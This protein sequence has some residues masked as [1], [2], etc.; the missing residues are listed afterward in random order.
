MILRELSIWDLP[1]L[2]EVRND[3]TTRVNLENNSIFTLEECAEWFLDK[4]PN[5]YIIEVDGNSVGYIRTNGDEVGADIHPKY[6]KM[7]YAKQA[8][9]IYLKDKKSASLWVFNDNFAKNLY[10][11]L[12]FIETGNKKIIR[13]REYIQMAYKK[14]KIGIN[15]VGVSFDDGSIYRYRSYKDALDGFNKNIVQSL[16]YMGHDFQFYLYTYDSVQKEN[17]IKDYSPIRK[18]KFITKETDVLYNSFNLNSIQK[19]NYVNSLL[20]MLNEELDLVISTRYDI[21]FFKN[22]FQEYK[23]D[24]N[25]MNFLWRE[26]EYIDLPIVNDTFV[27]FPYKMLN[28]VIRSIVTMEKNPPNGVNVAMHNWYLPMV[29]EVGID[30]VHWL[31][32]E[33]VKGLPNKLYNLTR[34]A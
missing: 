8:Y 26:P 23:F 34:H 3:E 32:D 20:E 27:V 4:T 28:N 19:I 15:L 6:R 29:D 9:R 11:N 22:P 14:L 25:K 5:W 24:F 10:K 21:N 1:F 2:L 17:I 33:F 16:N 31:D 13:Q 18:Y 12:G 7:G 30:N